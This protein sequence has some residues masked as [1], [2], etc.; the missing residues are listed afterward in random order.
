MGVK[1]KTASNNL[2]KSGARTLDIHC[3]EQTVNILTYGTDMHFME[4]LCGA[5][6]QELIT[7]L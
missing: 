3:P 7:E 1:T 4:K 2:N 6:R 5:N